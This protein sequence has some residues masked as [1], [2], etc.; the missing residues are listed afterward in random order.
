MISDSNNPQIEFS[1]IFTDQLD[2]APMVIKI[3]FRDVLE[4]FL[5]NPFHPQL[6]NHQL[7]QKLSAYRSIDVTEDW[8]AL[9]ITRR[10]RTRIVIIFHMFG[11]HQQS[12][13]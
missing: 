4:L 7:Q 9:F 1:Q 3:A 5:D 13:K 10:S 6:R 8:R 12:Y 2:D 11:T